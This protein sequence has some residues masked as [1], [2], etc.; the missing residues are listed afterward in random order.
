[1]DKTDYKIIQILQEDGRISMTKLSQ[2]VNL[3][4]PS[5]IERVKKLEN[6][7]VIM[8]YSAQIDPI[9]LGRKFNAFV[10]TSA[11]VENREKCM[12]FVESDSRILQAYRMT[13]RFT[14]CMKI[15]CE[16]EEDFHDLLDTFYKFG[17]FETYMITKELREHQGMISI[18]ENMQRIK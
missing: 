3:S 6:S 17:T 11:T 15:S 18:L 5:T 7:G 10:L 14:G 9:K 12:R 4:T 16:S 2:M 8:G 13:G 1:M